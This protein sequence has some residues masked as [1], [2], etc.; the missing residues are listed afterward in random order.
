MLPEVVDNIRCKDAQ[1]I[2][3]SFENNLS[4]SPNS[5]QFS[6]VSTDVLEHLLMNRLGSIRTTTGHT[7]S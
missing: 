3:I 5:Y 4:G 2:L 6:G 1:F 7:S